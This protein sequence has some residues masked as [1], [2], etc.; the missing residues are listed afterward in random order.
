[1]PSKVNVPNICIHQQQCVKFAT[2]SYSTCTHVIK[3]SRVRLPFFN[4]LPDV[5]ISS[6]YV[7]RFT[8]VRLPVSEYLHNGA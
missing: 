7:N 3:P 6:M 5:S 8:T 4:R 2:N 1:M